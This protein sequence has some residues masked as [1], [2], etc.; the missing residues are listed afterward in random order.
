[1]FEYYEQTTQESIKAE[2]CWMLSNIAAS[3]KNEIEYLINHP[4]YYKLLE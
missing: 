4:F 2:L 3:S 1:M